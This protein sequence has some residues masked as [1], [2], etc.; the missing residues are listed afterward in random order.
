MTEK[1]IRELKYGDRVEM[2]EG[3]V[4]TIVRIERNCLI[5]KAGDIA[6][7]VTYRH[8]EGESTMHGVGG[9]DCVVSLG[10]VQ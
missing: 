2:A 7:D 6:Y 10:A 1:M 8:D 9:T 4:A 3:G 5:E